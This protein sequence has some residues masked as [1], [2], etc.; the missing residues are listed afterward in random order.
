MFRDGAESTSM[1][2]R[3][4]T[5]HN[6]L[7]RF[8]QMSVLVVL[9]QNGKMAKRVVLREVLFVVLLVKPGIDAYR[10]VSKV[11]QRPGTVITPHNELVYI[12]GVEL[13]LESIPGAVIQATAI[14][15]GQTSTIAV[16]SLTSSIVTAAFISA[17][18]SVEKDVDS[19][20]RRESPDFYGLL[21]LD[22]KWKTVCTSLL[23]MLLAMCQLSSKGEKKQSEF[24][25]SY[26]RYKLYL[27][28]PESHR[29][30]SLYH[31]E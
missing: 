15:G 16:L 4:P 28:A 13:L 2:E 11:K 5:Q 26:H 6:L 9:I 31:R 12:R 25:K 10:V 22:S 24:C 29:L 27:G 14:V 17:S 20:C 30:R 19:K 23:I 7:A 3:R 1:R 8:A 21:Q 18:I